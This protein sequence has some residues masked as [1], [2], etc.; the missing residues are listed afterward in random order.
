MNLIIH[1]DGG[2]RGNPGP[3]A[4]GVVIQDA[5]THA[6]LHEAGYWLG[7]ATNNTAEYQGLLRSLQIIVGM[8][9]QQVTIYS[10][11]ELLVRQI[12]GQYRVKAPTIKPLFES[13]Q[14]LLQQLSTWQ[15]HH[16]RREKNQRADE[17]ANVA[18][19][20]KRDVIVESFPTDATT[21]AT[22]SPQP[23]ATAPSNS[24]GQNAHTGWIIG[25]TTDAGSTCSAKHTADQA[26]H[27]DHVTP[28]GLC[29]HAAKAVLGSY[30][31]VTPCEIACPRC[32]VGIRIE[33]ANGP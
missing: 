10:D 31:P 32:G 13:A 9:P 24:D 12:N 11:S 28:A 17:L 23:S 21:P 5:E 19:D 4:A 16:V 27:M 22:S 20:A 26:F 1:I 7:T 25:F 8:K 3:A 6:P 33:P 18:M 2:A 30:P 14:N 29:I 15:I